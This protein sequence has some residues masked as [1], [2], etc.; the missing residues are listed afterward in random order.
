MF[1]ALNVS[2][3]GCHFEMPTVFK[4]SCVCV[5]K[6]SAGS[7]E[8]PLADEYD[9]VP[10]EVE[11][12]TDV[13]P[14]YILGDFVARSLINNKS[15][16]LIGTPGTKSEFYVELDAKRTTLWIRLVDKQLNA[17]SLEFAEIVLHFK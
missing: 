3:G 2:N 9:Y 11:E 1:V 6:M 13:F 5:V 15:C 7:R 12:S 14:S 4:Y 10:T 17:V 16:G 8:E